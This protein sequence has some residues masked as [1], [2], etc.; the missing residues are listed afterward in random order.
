MQWK[1]GCL[2]GL[3]EV[4]GFEEDRQ[5]PKG[6]RS[7]QHV[8]ELGA[9]FTS[10][11]NLWPPHWSSAALTFCNISIW[12]TGSERERRGE[13]G[14]RGGGEGGKEEGRRRDDS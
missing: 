7:A 8:V 2:L 12:E 3:C 6:P 13:M 1:I 4:K 14:R 9:E 11:Q 10:L 5:V